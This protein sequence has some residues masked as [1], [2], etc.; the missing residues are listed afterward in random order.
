[1]EKQKAKQKILIDYFSLSI[2]SIICMKHSIGTQLQIDWTSVDKPQ[3]LQIGC[4]EKTIK[5]KFSAYCWLTK[6]SLDYQFFSFIEL[7][8]KN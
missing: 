2:C 3:I 7:S 6:L 4:T 1:M 5:R 8:V